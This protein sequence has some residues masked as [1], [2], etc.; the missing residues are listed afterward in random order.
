MPKNLNTLCTNQSS[1]VIA[2]QFEAQSYSYDLV[3]NRIRT[4]FDLLSI[5]ERNFFH[6]STPFPQL[7]IERCDTG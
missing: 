2:K 3:S 5:R 6:D 1:H 4:S 7:V